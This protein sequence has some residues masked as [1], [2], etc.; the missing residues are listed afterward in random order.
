MLREIAKGLST[1][2]FTEFV[3]YVFNHEKYEQ[4][5]MEDVYV[6]VCNAVIKA[7]FYSNKEIVKIIDGLFSALIL[8]CAANLK[9]QRQSV[10]NIINAII[11]K[12][13]EYYKTNGREVSLFECPFGEPMEVSEGT[14]KWFESLKPGSRVDCL[15][16]YGGKKHWSRGE[17]TCLDPSLTRVR[18]LND[19]MDSFIQNKFFDIAPLGT[20]EN[21]FDW[22]QGLK[23]GNLVDGYNFR[24][25]WRLFRITRVTTDENLYGEE[26]RL[27]HLAVEKKPSATANDPKG[28]V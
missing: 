8:F 12:S 7:R 4:L 5:F 21:D 25:D 16:S 6:H 10:V 1:P 24:N 13:F 23:V 9:R 11:D 22:R 19:N 27:L 20:R 14:R 2:S 15:K 17:L 26:V 18:F 3:D 28:V